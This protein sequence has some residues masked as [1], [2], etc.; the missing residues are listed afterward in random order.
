MSYQYLLYEKNAGIARITLN[1]PKSLNA[2]GLGMVAELREVFE[3]ASKEKNIK[4]VILRGS[5]RGF[6]AGGDV[7]LMSEGLTIGVGREWVNDIGKIVLSIMTMDKP[8]IAAINGAA[9]G[10]GCN[11]ALAC[12]FTVAS[13]DAVFCEVFSRIGLIPD[14]GGAFIVPRLVGL[15]RA[16]EMIFLAKEVSA[17]EAKDIGLIQ[18]VVPA[19]KLDETTEALAVNLVEGYTTSFGMAKMLLFQNFAGEFG[20]F[21]ETESAIQALCMESADHKQKIKEFFEKRT[22]RTSAGQ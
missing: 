21:L 14:A 1:T 11:L 12:D 15:A 9:F 5:G 20:R 4:V 2:L 8:V 10:A 13:E 18:Y 3:D 17:R 6:C 22:K 7:K 19:S 16:K